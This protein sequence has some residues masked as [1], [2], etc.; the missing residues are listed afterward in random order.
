MKTLRR[1]ITKLLLATLILVG[2]S[3]CNTQIDKEK[4]NESLTSAPEQIVTVEQ[5]KKMYDTYGTRRVP[6]IQR[7][8]D[9]INRI[10]YND[11]MGRQKTEKTQDP[12]KSIE[13]KGKHFDVTRYVYYEYDTIKKYM[14][15]IEKEAERA[16]VKISTLRFYL[17]NYPEKD[18][19]PKDSAARVRQNSIFITPTIKEKKKEYAYY[20]EES[21]EGQLKMILLDDNLNTSKTR[22]TGN[23]YESDRKSFASFLPEISSSK[24]NIAPVFFSKNSYALN[25]GGGAPPPYN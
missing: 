18:M 15:Y 2:F 22:L 3:N 19:F 4:P 5:A 12:E 6:L 14:A 13:M 7:Y 20:G 16:G 17:S 21:A 8:E 24:A 25:K 10:G 23:L 1:R 9:S 11:K